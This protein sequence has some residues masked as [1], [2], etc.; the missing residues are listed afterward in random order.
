M[1]IPI[2]DLSWDV[3]SGM[4]TFKTEKNLNAYLD[5]L[6]EDIKMNG[7][8]LPPRIRS[9]TPMEYRRHSKKYRVLQGN[10][11]CEIVKK[12]GWKEIEVDLCQIH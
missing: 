3:K 5:R 1:K 9:S 2:S 12:L 8:T 11:R 4:A 7:I 10:H 6:E